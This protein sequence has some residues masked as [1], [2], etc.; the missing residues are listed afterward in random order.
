MAVKRSFL[1]CKLRET[2]GEGRWC[3]SPELTSRR[4]NRTGRGRRTDSTWRNK[5]D[6]PFPEPAGSSRRFG[7][8]PTGAR[9]TRSSAFR[10]LGICIFRAGSSTKPGK[11]FRRGRRESSRACTEP[12]S[13]RASRQIGP[14]GPDKR[15]S[16]RTYP[17]GS[18]EPV[19]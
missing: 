16:T 12:R 18:P 19:L 6:G 7:R 14:G 10:K 3:R 2:G 17:T 15:P 11:R 8:R 5:T 4:R 9:R 1:I 13:R